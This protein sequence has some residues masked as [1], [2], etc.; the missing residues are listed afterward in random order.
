MQSTRVESRKQDAVIVTDAESKR[1]E[2]AEEV[3]RPVKSGSPVVQNHQDTVKD[4]GTDKTAAV[5]SDG[6]AGEDRRNVDENY[7]SRKER[8]R[9]RTKALREVQ[10]NLTSNNLAWSRITNIV[11]KQNNY[12]RKG[13]FHDQGG[14]NG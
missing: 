2:R 9:L 1:E 8:Y 13:E 6:K 4:S 3:I 5:S 10:K 11:E 12:I 14:S 7:D